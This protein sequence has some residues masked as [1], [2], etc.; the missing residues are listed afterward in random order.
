M[1]K[2]PL[3]VDVRGSKTSLFKFPIIDSF[4]NVIILGAGVK[5]WKEVQFNVALYL[6]CL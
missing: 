5:N 3:P 6:R 4:V 2:S 1:K